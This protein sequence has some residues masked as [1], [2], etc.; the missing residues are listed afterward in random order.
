MGNDVQPLALP[1]G[2]EVDAMTGDGNRG[3]F[4]W[5]CYRGEDGVFRWFVFLAG[6]LVAMGHEDSEIEAEV[7]AVHSI[8]LT[9]YYAALD[10]GLVPADSS[11]PTR[12]T[13]PHGPE[14][15]A[16]SSVEWD[17]KEGIKTPGSVA[18]K[19]GS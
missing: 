16:G 2:L 4:I 5:K 9:A 1:E 10:C 12:P 3:E 11:P 7:S 14:G 18:L 17:P 6:S 15:F 19:A 8:V 13:S